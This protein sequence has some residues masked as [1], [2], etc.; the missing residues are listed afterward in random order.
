[1]GSESDLVRQVETV[2]LLT[3]W[4][5]LHFSFM[6]TYAL[7]LFVSPPSFFT[8]AS[9]HKFLCCFVRETPFHGVLSFCF[10]FPLTLAE[11]LLPVFAHMAQYM[12][13]V[14]TY[15]V[16]LLFSAGTLLYLPPT[17]YTYTKVGVSFVGLFLRFALGMNK[18]HHFG[19]SFTWEAG[20]PGDGS[21]GWELC[22]SFLFF[23]SSFTH[24]FLVLLSFTGGSGGHSHLSNSATF[25]YTPAGLSS[26]IFSAFPPACSPAWHLDILFFLFQGLSCLHTILGFLFL[27]F[28]FCVCCIWG[29]FQLSMFISHFLSLH[30]PAFLSHTHTLLSS[31][32]CIFVCILPLSTACL[33]FYFTIN[34]Q[35]LLFSFACLSLEAC[36][37]FG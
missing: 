15:L 9:F 34:I 4:A 35:T 37:L 14:P 21:Y 36:I 23:L 11:H 12:L 26:T 6:H 10:L 1:M 3:G 29:L 19:F 22:F 27:F 18:S 28:T 25:S 7:L 13:S 24:N 31:L 2:S 33:I 8:T 5:F 16:S 30:M 20:G 17:L 32:S